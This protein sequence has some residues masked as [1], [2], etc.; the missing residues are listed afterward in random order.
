MKK[1]ITILVSGIIV[2]LLVAC[3][4]KA[5]VDNEAP[6]PADDIGIVNPWTEVSSLL[7]RQKEQV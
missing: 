7:M 1:F 3:G 2:I 6:V 5:Q 4:K